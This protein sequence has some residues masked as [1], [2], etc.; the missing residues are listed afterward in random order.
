M[1]KKDKTRNQSYSGESI[2]SKLLS[3]TGIGKLLGYGDNTYTDGYGVTRENAPL[4]E[5]AQGQQLDRMKDTAVNAANLVAAGAAFGNPITAETWLAPVITA[6]QAYYAGAGL[7]DGINRVESM[8]EDPSQ[9]TAENVLITGLETLPVVPAAKTVIKGAK[10]VV[11]VAKQ[12]VKEAEAVNYAGRQAD[13]AAA[14]AAKGTVNNTGVTDVVKSEPYARIAPS[15]GRINTAVNYGLRYDPQNTV[16]LVSDTEPG[17]YSV[18]FKT[19]QGSQT[20]NNIQSVVDQIVTD[21]P[22]GA[23]LGTWGTVSKGG[24]SGLNRF[25][26]AGMIKTGEY[27][28]L[29]FKDPSVANEVAKKYGLTL[30][31]D[32][33]INWPIRRKLYDAQPLPMAERLGLTKGE[34]NSMSRN[35]KEGLEDLEYLLDLDKKNLKLVM[36]DGKAQYVSEL[37]P[38]ETPLWVDLAKKGPM[39][40]MGYRVDT[41][42]GIVYLEP[43]INGQEKVSIYA[44]NFPTEY[45]DASS[46][47]AG[48]GSQ[49]L[50]MTSPYRSYEAETGMIDESQPKTIPKEVIR[51]FLRD[52]ETFTRPG[53]YIGGDFTRLPMGNSLYRLWKNRNT[54]THPIMND[55]TSSM[56]KRGGTLNTVYTMLATPEK[57]QSHLDGL[58]TDSYMLILKQGNRPGHKLRFSND[59]FTTFNSQG[60][61]YKPIYDMWKQTQTGEIPQQTFVDAFNKW[62]KPYNGEPAVIKNGEIIIPQPFVLYQ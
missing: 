33:T 48:D 11:P 38:G 46:T 17:Y 57:T 49:S 26:D 52:V 15:D 59:G 51:G 45:G 24:F 62:V 18:H 8:V 60:V 42:T 4:S 43:T 2:A 9:R 13:A 5:S 58:S 16:Q 34:R 53:T 7:H 37:R 35:Q 30:N 12:M 22:A 20:S 23:K 28:P 10:E 44:K 1:A 32:G 39:E 41:P 36:R 3:G 55:G 19:N 61:R 47:P 56:P 40:T 27:R 6:A 54:I 25:S 21:L 14:T 31:T 50:I 29:A